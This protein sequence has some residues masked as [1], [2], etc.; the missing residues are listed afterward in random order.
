MSIV[1]YNPIWDDFAPTSFRSL[2]DRFFNDSLTRAGGSTPVFVPRV[3]VVETDKAYEVQVAVP[4]MN[5]EDFKLDLNDG[6]LAIS[7]ERKIKSDRDEGSYR[8]RETQYGSFSRRFTLPEDV[9]ADSIVA[10]YN[11]GI[12]EVTLP[13]DEKKVVKSTI[14]VR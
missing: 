13:K 5:K 14:P 4:G 11:N 1:R 8:V 7:G 12:L 6:I 2:V 10:K 9:K 3:D